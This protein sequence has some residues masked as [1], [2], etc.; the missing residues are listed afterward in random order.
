MKISSLMSIVL[1]LAV[2]SCAT[3]G[4]PDVAEAPTV[5]V[6]A[7]RILIVYL[8]R[9]KNTKA[10]AEI[11][12]QKVGGKLVALELQDPYPADYKTTV[13]QVARENTSG[14]LPALATRIDSI[15]K[16]D[17]IFLGFPTWGMQL[18][19][20][21]RSFLT[22]YNLNGKT[23]APFNTNAGYGIGTSF[24]QVKSLAAGSNVLD[25]F[26]TQ[27]GIERDGVLFVMQGDKQVQVDGQVARW[28]QGLKLP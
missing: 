22:Q 2:L 18:P 11:I 9:T 21:I 5:N 16:Y 20:P 7:D 13:D 19:P 27:G 12:Q 3:N 26:S 4:Q 14:F 24:D 8:S 23:I 6:P 10:V 25:G 15:E 1:L 17:M 28:L